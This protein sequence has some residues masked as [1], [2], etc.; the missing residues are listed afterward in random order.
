MCTSSSVARWTTQEA[1]VHDGD[2]EEVLGQSSRLEIV[3]IGFA[4]PP[5]KAHRTWPSELELQHA[6]HESL[7]LED[8]IDRIA[9]VDHVDDF[10]D[11][12]TVDLLVLGSNEDGSGTDKLKLAERDDLA[13]KEAVD[14]VDAEEEGFGEETEAVVHLDEPVHEDGAHRPLDLGLVVHVVGVREHFDLWMESAVVS[15]KD[16][17]VKRTSSSFMYAN[18]SSP[19]SA[20]MLMSQASSSISSA[21]LDASTTSLAAAISLLVLLLTLGKSMVVAPPVVLS[22]RRDFEGAVT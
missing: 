5:Q 15:G 22:P 19:Y 14:V 8:L 2:L 11:R 20:T 17:T 1:L 7:G 9:V 16:G 4:D 12:W 10:L 6:K 3:I 13:G 21:V 18:I